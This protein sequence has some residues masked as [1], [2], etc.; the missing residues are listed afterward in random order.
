MY[1]G[2]LQVCVGYV[3]N[4]TGNFRGVQKTNNPA[5]HSLPRGFFK[6]ET[7]C[8]FW[9]VSFPCFAGIPKYIFLT[10]KQLVKDGHVV[11]KERK[12]KNRASSELLRENTLSFELRY[13]RLLLQRMGK[14][15]QDLQQEYETPR[16]KKARARAAD[17]EASAE[18]ATSDDS[19]DE[20]DT[21]VRYV[22][23]EVIVA[24][25]GLLKTLNQ[26]R[27]ALGL[28][29]DEVFIPNSSADAEQ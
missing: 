18:Q 12:R 20:D 17:Q 10:A 5:L 1:I 9:G 11:L 23:D 13:R 19:S 8:V 22:D 14:Q 26:Q 4:L 2:S 29:P 27:I 15:Y 25:I 16:G 3:S 7:L 21:E 28:E 24:V 6:A